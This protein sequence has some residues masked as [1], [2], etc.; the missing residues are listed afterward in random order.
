MPQHHIMEEMDFR[1]KR[2]AQS[3]SSKAMNPVRAAADHR[4]TQLYPLHSTPRAAQARYNEDDITFIGQRGPAPPIPSIPIQRPPLMPT[5]SQQAD[6]FSI[7]TGLGRYVVKGQAS[8]P[9]PAPFIQNDFSKYFK[10]STPGAFQRYHNDRPIGHQ[11]HVA[12]SPSAFTRPVFQHKAVAIAASTEVKPAPD[13]QNDREE[14]DLQAVRIAA[15]DMDRYHGDAEKHMRELLAGAIGDAD[16]GIAEGED[17]I[18]GFAENVRLMPHQV[19]GVRWMRDRETGRKYGG[20]LADV[21][22]AIHP[23]ISDHNRIWGS[24]RRFRP[25]LG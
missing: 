19:R 11:Q 3:S 14:F 20:I 22:V 2:L 25:W 1:E 23:V 15:E 17:V 10:P 9:D 6:P 8:R 13:E 18:E 7:G 21:R 5:Q 4:N 24:E 16:E 12:H